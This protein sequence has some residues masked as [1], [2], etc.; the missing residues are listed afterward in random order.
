MVSRVSGNVQIR[1]RTV[2]SSCSMSLTPWRHFPGCPSSTKIV[3]EIPQVGSDDDVHK[4]VD[5]HH[6]EC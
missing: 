3:V 5:I 4:T 6:A 1:P 2:L